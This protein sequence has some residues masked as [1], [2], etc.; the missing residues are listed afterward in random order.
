MSKGK[1]T[2]EE[3][4]M[5]EE[6]NRYRDIFGRFQLPRHNDEHGLGQPTPKVITKRGR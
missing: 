3:E 4:R 6:E 5:E 1:K 2:R